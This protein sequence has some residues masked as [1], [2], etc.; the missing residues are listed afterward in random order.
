MNANIE[1]PAADIAWMRRLAEEGR[2]APLLNG[3]VMVA[4][5]LIF[6]AA[7]GVQWAIQAGVLVV[8]PMVQLWVWLGAGAV[9]AVALFLLIRRASR[10]PGYGSHG[11]KAVGAAWSGIGFGIFV[12]WLSLMAVGFR[13][14]DWTMMWA[15]PS[16]VATAYGTAWIVSGAMAGRR[17]MTATGLLAYAGAILFGALIGDPVIYLAFTAFMVVT[18]LIPGLALMRQE[19]AEA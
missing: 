1:D 9:F 14:G 19:P 5:G 13:S 7:N 8:D 2:D 15:M 17:W 18:A 3:P 12:M 4:A 6:G 11:N 10:K 16:V